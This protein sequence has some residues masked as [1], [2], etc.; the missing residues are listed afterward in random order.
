MNRSVVLVRSLPKNRAAELAELAEDYANHYNL[1]GPISPETIAK[2]AG[3]SYSFGDYGGRFDGLLEYEAGAFHIYCDITRNGVQGSTRSRFTFSHEL[4][5]YLIDEHRRELE[6]GRSLFHPSFTEYQSQLLV[7]KE[8]DYFAGHLLMPQTRFEKTLNTWKT[9]KGLDLIK[10]I[11]NKFNVSLTSAAF[12]ISQTGIQKS[13][14][15]KWS[16]DGHLEWYW[17]CPEFYEYDLKSPIKEISKLGTTSAAFQA[18]NQTHRFDSMDYKR[19]KAR[20]SFFFP[21][22]TDR[23]SNENPL[24]IEE[25]MQ[26]GQFGYLSFVYVG[27]PF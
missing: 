15:F 14:V 25:A 19:E 11:A 2:D 9:R 26:L 5:H 8:A 1:L 7:E 27:R 21:F 3:I 13:A 24:V 6:S 16:E 4:G 20:L 18:F 12:R 17:V 10:L 23:S 22:L